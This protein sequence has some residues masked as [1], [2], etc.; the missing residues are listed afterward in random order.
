MLSLSKV[1]TETNQE[2]DQHP[3]QQLLGH[4]IHTTWGKANHS[5]QET[6]KEVIREKVINNNRKISN[7]GDNRERKIH[8]PFVAL[9]VASL[10]Q[11]LSKS[12]KIL[13]QCF[14]VMY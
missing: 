6:A 11:H 3:Q 13:G 5:Q 1:L 4:R 8:S 2:E 10:L 14:S 7:H 12:F 9:S